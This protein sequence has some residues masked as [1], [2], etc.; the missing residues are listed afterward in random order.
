MRLTRLLA[1]LL[2]TAVAFPLAGCGKDPAA[3]T[4]ATVESTAFAPTLGVDVSATGW[5]RSATGLYYRPL[6]TPAGTAATVATGQRVA[7]RYT[8]YL[9]TGE[10]FQSGEFE[11]DAGRGQVIAGFDEGIVGMR[12][13]ERRRLLIP[14]SL[15]YGRSGSRA[16][17]GNAVLVFDVEVLAAA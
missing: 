8:G 5:T 10:Q 14:P 17:P 12:V 1:P 2:A 4:L 16:I 13:G 3:P 9:S 6:N 7:V 15:G 11:F